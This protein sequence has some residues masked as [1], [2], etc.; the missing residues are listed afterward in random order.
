ML[1]ALW[2]RR[3]RFAIATI[4]AWGTLWLVAAPQYL[5]E[6]LFKVAPSQAQGS[7]EVINVAPL[8][9]VNRLLHP[10]ALY[11]SGLGGGGLVLALAGVIGLAVLLV[12][13]VRLGSPRSDRD[14]RALEIAAATSVSMLVVPLSYAG[15][16][17][18]L[19]LPMIVLLDFGLR[20]GSRA[21]VVAVAVSWVLIGPSFLA[22]TNALAAG[23]GFQ[24]LFQVWANSPVVGVAVLWVTSL[25][26]L[27]LQPVSAS[28]GKVREPSHPF[29]PRLS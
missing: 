24:Q 29:M 2:G 26:A 18:L 6:Y 10:Q 1:L 16:F 22:F 7:P 13:A 9:T 4:A 23:V 8:G 17:M 27:G 3:Y 21:T 25:Y 15:Q 5:F 28:T 19:L 12:T 11:N 20:R 14:G